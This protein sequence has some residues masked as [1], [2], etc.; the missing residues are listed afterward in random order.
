MVDRRD[1]RVCMSAKTNV[2]PKKT[3]REKDKEKVEALT[4]TP[5]KLMKFYQ[6]TRQSN[7]H[8]LLRP[9]HMHQHPDNEN[10]EDIREESLT[11][12]PFFVP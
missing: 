6:N 11:P 5:S 12:P 10:K 4:R 9:F 1:V 3:R 7:V 8:G 2:E